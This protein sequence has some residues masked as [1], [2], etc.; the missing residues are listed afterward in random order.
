MGASTIWQKSTVVCRRSP[1][2]TT[3]DVTP[4]AIHR[5]SADPWAGV[6]KGEK[7]ASLVPQE[8]QNPL[9]AG[10]GAWLEHYTKRELQNDRGAA[11]MASALGFVVR[12][13]LWSI[14]VLL[15][16][17]NLGFNIT[18]LMAVEQA[19]RPNRGK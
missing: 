2:S 16:L 13:G 6:E 19:R 8:P 15:C 1:S 5:A 14:L 9:S 12:L 11:T 10:F 17:D 18:T 7:G 3:P 4:C